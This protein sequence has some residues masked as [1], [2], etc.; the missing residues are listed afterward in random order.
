MTEADHDQQ[1]AIRTYVSDIPHRS[2]PDGVAVDAGVSQVAR[3]NAEQSWLR[4]AESV[5]H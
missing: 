3:K 1:H 4:A 2:A 5:A